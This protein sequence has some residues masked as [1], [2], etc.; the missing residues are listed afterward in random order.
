MQKTLH[1]KYYYAFITLLWAADWPEWSG[2]PPDICP[3]ETPPQGKNSR[4][5]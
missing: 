1:A 3:G 2:L 5:K 4:T